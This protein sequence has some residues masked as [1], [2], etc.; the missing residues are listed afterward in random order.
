MIPISPILCTQCALRKNNRHLK[1][2]V[3]QD[4]SILKNFANDSMMSRFPELTEH[5]FPQKFIISHNAFTKR[6][7]NTPNQ[8]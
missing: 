5:A 3:F 7:L 8:P 1:G 2:F 6:L 4:E